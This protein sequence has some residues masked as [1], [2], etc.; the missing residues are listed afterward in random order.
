MCAQESQPLLKSSVS[1]ENTNKFMRSVFHYYYL[2]SKG[3]KKSA[4]IDAETL[5]EA[6][7]K[8]RAQ[9]IFV[10]SLKQQKYLN[11]EK[12]GS[13]RQL[14]TLITQLA[15]LLIAGIPLYESL[16]AL[17]EQYKEERLHSVLTGL[18]EQIK[19]GASL[20]EA[21]EQYPSLFTRLYIA[22][23]AAGESIGA[24]DVTLN[25]LSFLLSNQS[26]LKKQLTTALIYPSL[27]FAFSGI[28]VLLLLLFVIPSMEMLFED[29]MVNRFTYMVIGVSRFL[30]TQW[31]FYLPTFSLLIGGLIFYGREKKKA[32]LTALLYIPILGTLMTQL[33][34]ARFT[35]TL[36]TLLQG[37]VP[38][39][40]A[41]QISRNVMHHPLFEE[42]V[43]E[44]E[45]RMIEG[46]FLSTELKKS[47][48]IP[49][50]VPR[51][52]A[53]GEEAGT[54]GPMLGKIADLYEE[55]VDKTLTRLMALVQP[56]VLIVMGGIVGIIM[57]AVLLP[58]TDATSFMS[59]G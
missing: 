22:L 21:M 20:S 55:E 58:L 6:K 11:K 43:E 33:I 32:L 57:L 2:T 25:K 3:K 13:N 1:P 12:E 9:N 5:S 59:G 18:A 31:M 8:L 26:K 41:M 36:G 38:I 17:Q 39:I 54:L 34:L 42:T 10:I 40:Q 46:S 4:L 37:G 27:L 24:L 16:L 56:V 50:L 47:K 35:R 49:S 23:V 44:A 28:V 45:K 52:L 19:E 30:R 51:M 53:I 7:E 15:Q 29:R 48:W 14:P